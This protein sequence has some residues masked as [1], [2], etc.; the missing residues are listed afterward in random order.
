V[1]R[2]FH[3]YNTMVLLLFAGL[4]GCQQMQVPVAP[5]SD[6]SNINWKG[7][8][9]QRDNLPTSTNP[10]E[11]I[12]AEAVELIAPDTTMTPETDLPVITIAPQDLDP[13]LVLGKSPEQLKSQLGTPSI[14]KK[15]G[16]VEIWQYQLSD[17]V[18]DF[19]FYDKAG[20]LAV[21]HTDMRSPFL[22]GQLDQTACRQALYK[23]SQ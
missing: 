21:T 22:G 16:N 10:N 13:Q 19:F 3:L 15:E 17:C 14:L 18:I 1:Y 4:A 20:T 7:L 2:V 5:V 6:S 23:M 9:F 8:T 12:E 11:N